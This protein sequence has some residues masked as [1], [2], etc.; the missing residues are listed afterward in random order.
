MTISYSGGVFQGFEDLCLPEEDV[1][2]TG[3]P[4][5]TLKGPHTLLVDHASH[6]AVVESGRESNYRVLTV[7]FAYGYITQAA[8]PNTHK[9]Q[10]AF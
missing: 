6:K 9:H 8:M 4:Q 1:A 3:S 5:H 10:H 7:A 2:S